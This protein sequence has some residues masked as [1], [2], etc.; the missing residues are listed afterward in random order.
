M[1]EMKEKLSY[2]AVH[3]KGVFFEHKLVESEDFEELGR[4]YKALLADLRSVYREGL[5]AKLLREFY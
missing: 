5:P 4:E 2:A 1:R 3:I